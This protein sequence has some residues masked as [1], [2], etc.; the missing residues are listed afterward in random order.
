MHNGDQVG[1]EIARTRF[2]YSCLQHLFRVLESLLT[3]TAGDAWLFVAKFDFV[4]FKN[5]RHQV[6]IE[7]NGELKPDHKHEFMEIA[8]TFLQLNVQVCVC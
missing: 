8:D 3:G 7:R 2:L 5:S 6:S 4:I 1:M